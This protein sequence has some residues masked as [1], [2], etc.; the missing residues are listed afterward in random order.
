M[1]RRS[2]T[3][4]VIDLTR[5][6]DPTEVNIALEKVTKYVN[7]YASGG[8]ELAD[9][10]IA[11]VFHADATLAVLN[12]D[13]YA[14]AFGTKDNPNI[15]LLQMLQPLH[16]ANVQMYVCGQTLVSKGSPPEAVAVFIETAVS[17]LT[18]VANL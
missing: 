18:A 7:I 16:A 12:S 13:A 11:V 6:G 4:F 10:Q 9:V 14:K 2:V 8:A 3:K 5:G 1:Q 15:K 17:A